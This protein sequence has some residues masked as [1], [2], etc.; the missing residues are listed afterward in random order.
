MDE[1]HK[2][3]CAMGINEE[4]KHDFDS[5][6]VKD[7]AQVWNMIRRDGRVGLRRKIKVVCFER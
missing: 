6:H 5:C 7:V 3:V 2:I 4:E 1:V